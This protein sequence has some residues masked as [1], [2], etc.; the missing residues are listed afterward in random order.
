M[1]ANN[2]IKLPGLLSVGVLV[3]A[4][5]A[6][7]GIT[8]LQSDEKAAPAPETPISQARDYVPAPYAGTSTIVFYVVENDEQAAMVKFAEDELQTAGWN[9]GEIQPRSYSIHKVTSPEEGAAVDLMI[10]TSMAE[11]AESNTTIAQVVDFR[12]K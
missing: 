2:R 11:L 5:V 10:G 1:V 7:G 8:A 6:A 9:N 3:A 12:G 4:L